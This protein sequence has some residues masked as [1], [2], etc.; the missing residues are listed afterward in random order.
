MAG[1]AHPAGPVRRPVYR[2]GSGLDVHALQDGLPLWLAGVQVDHPRGLAGHSDGDAV[3]HALVDA[4]LGATA[5]GDI[6]QWFPSTDDRWRGA[7][8]RAFVEHVWGRL[9]ADGWWVEN[10]DLTIV[11]S[12]PRLTPYRDAMRA[13]IA[14]MLD[15]GQE[16]VSIKATTT[17]GLGALGRAEGVLAL[18]T[19]LLS[20]E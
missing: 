5:L 10:V 1:A 4:L 7:P 6:G 13:S 9:H 20:R 3:L 12:E 16:A 17:D 19:V 8:S 14:A 15:I 18:A 11:A 2:V